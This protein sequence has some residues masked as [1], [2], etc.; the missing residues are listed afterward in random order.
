MQHRCTFV[1]LFR[2]RYVHM[3]E[4]RLLMEMDTWPVIMFALVTAAMS[5]WLST[6]QA[7]WYVRHAH[8]ARLCYIPIAL[9]CLWIKSTIWLLILSS[10][11]FMV[12]RSRVFRKKITFARPMTMETRCCPK[13]SF[14]FKYTRHQISVPLAMSTNLHKKSCKLSRKTREKKSWADL[15]PRSAWKKLAHV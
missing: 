7:A 9:W 1:Q 2:N 6:L 12:G 3:Y 5:R 14:N 15:G 13:K 4:I 8:W 10:A 11:S